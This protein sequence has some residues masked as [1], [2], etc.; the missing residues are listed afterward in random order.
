VG[1]KTSEQVLTMRKRTG[2]GVANLN[3]QVMMAGWA[4]PNTRDYRSPNQR[5]YEARG[6]GKKGEQLPNQVEHAVRT[7]LGVTS[8]GST[9]STKNSVRSLKA[10]KLLLN[11]LFSGWLMGY[12]TEWLAAAPSE[13]PRPTKK[14]TR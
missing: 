10:P 1:G 7:S 14:P 5:T 9:A 11:T 6:G 13:M 12:N 8:N 2:A 4:A 3:E